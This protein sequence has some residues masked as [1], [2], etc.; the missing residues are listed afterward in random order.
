M[1][2]ASRIDFQVVVLGVVLF[3]ALT[4]TPGCLELGKTG[5]QT[6]TTTV[7]DSTSKVSSTTLILHPIASCADLACV[8]R[9]VDKKD[10]NPEAC[11]QIRG[12]LRDECLNYYVLGRKSWN[13]DYCWKISNKSLRDNCLTSTNSHNREV[14]LENMDFEEG[15]IECDTILDE[16]VRKRCLNISSHLDEALRTENKSI[17]DDSPD[18]IYCM[19]L[20][21]KRLPKLKIENAAALGDLSICFDRDYTSMKECFNSFIYKTNKCPCGE[22]TEL[23]GNNREKLVSLGLDVDYVRDLCFGYCGIIFWDS[24]YC[25]KTTESMT[26]WCEGLVYSRNLTEGLL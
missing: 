12:N 10:F 1:V 17:C 23:N 26:H 22:I 5:V 6:Q 11:L 24:S 7:L 4:L 14:L 3:A 2:L 21:Q 15:L 16:F 25:L 9:E 19:G 18:R 8:K 20:Y 13:S